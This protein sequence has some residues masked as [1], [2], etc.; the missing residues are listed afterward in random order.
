MQQ[1]E[2][3]FFVNAAGGVKVALRPQSDFLVAGLASEADT[4][5]NQAF[6][7]SQAAGLRFHQQQAQLGNRL[8]FLNQEYRADNL[9]FALG[10]PAALALGI[11]VLDKV[12]NDLGDQGFEALVVAILLG[13]EHAMAMHHPTHVAGLIDR[14]STRLNSS[15]TVISY[16]V[17]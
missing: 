15:H 3:G 9:A 14:K 16:A 13:I 11:E 4:L 6:A 1:S 10:D 8:C 17:F 7:D 5:V 2:A 12:G